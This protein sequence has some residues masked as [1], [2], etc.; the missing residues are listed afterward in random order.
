MQ[1]THSQFGEQ[2]Q[3]WHFMVGLLWNASGASMH[4]N[5]GVE[6]PLHPGCR[7]SSQASDGWVPGKFPET[8]VWQ[9]V[10]AH[11]GTL[12]FRGQRPVLLERSPWGQ[13]EAE[14]NGDASK[15][16]IFRFFPRV[17]RKRYDS[18]PVSM[19]WA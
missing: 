13:A 7:T 15:G 19:M 14:P 6:N 3:L 4:T 12:S 9:L 2:V 17:L 10:L 18:A 1:F 5:A 11:F 8:C 16:H